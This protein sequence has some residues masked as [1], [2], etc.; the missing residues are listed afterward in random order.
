MLCGDKRDMVGIENETSGNA[1]L[2]KS[3][4]SNRMRRMSERC[5]NP[6]VALL[7]RVNETTDVV[8]PEDPI[9]SKHPLLPVQL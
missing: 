1:S 7:L 8:A 2:Q 5:D 9:P 4:P 6:W 3:L